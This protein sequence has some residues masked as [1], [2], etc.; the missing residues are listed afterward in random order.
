MSEGE[1]WCHWFLFIPVSGK[2]Q[3]SLEEAVDRAIEAGG[4]EY[5]AL[6]D[7]VVYNKAYYAI[8]AWGNAFRVR[9]VP[10]NTKEVVSQS[11]DILDRLIVHSSIRDQYKETSEKNLKR[12]SLSLSAETH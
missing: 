11:P 12:L 10:V 1:D 8:L 6:M 5:D 2:I 7:G 9:G 4:P 3:P